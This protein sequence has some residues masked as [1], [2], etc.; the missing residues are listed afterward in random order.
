[1]NLNGRTVILHDD[2][3]DKAMRKFKKKVAE[4]GILQTLQDKQCFIK[5][6]VRK[7]LA[8]GQAKKRWERYLNSQKLPTKQF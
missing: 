3:I 1:M 8:K 6:T 5:P 7:K 2:N 4:D